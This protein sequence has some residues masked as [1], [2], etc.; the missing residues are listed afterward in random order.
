MT[1]RT[2]TRKKTTTR[3]SRTKIDPLG[4]KAGDLDARLSQLESLIVA[5]SGGVDSAYL[6][7]TAARVL[8]PRA[9]AIT[10]VS[11]TT[12]VIP[13]PTVTYLSPN[14]TGSLS[15]TP[16]PNASGGKPDELFLES[17]VFAR[18]LSRLAEFV[19]AAR[20]EK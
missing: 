1:T 9:L 18:N 4:R 2:T 15:Y 12:S 14:A 17:E 16:V 13:N 10:A 19:G 11:G 20:D 6:A 7:V 5:F 8:G 3:T